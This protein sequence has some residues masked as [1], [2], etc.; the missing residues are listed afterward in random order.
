MHPQAV[1]DPKGECC[2]LTLGFLGIL[3]GK[4]TGGGS[5]SRKAC[6]GG[7]YARDG[8][9]RAKGQAAALCGIGVALPPSLTQPSESRGFRGCV[10]EPPRAQ[11]GSPGPMALRGSYSGQ[12]LACAESE[13]RYSVCNRQAVVRRK[14][15]A[16]LGSASRSFDGGEPHNGS[17]A[18][19]S[20]SL[21][22]G[23]RAR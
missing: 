4:R 20:L 11:Q 12:V 14:V 18:R 17:G 16:R 2:P 13:A 9:V 1:G 3:G 5:G 8:D 19:V 6:L 10:N 15:F 23:N 21:G 7:A 22:T